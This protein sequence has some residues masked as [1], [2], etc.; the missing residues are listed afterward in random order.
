[1]D[2]AARDGHDVLVSPISL[3][4]LVYLV[5]KNRRPAAAYDD[6]RDAL[7]DPDYAIEE[8][9]FHSEIVTAMRSVPR[10]SVPDLPDRIIA[11][12]ALFFGVP[13]LSRDGDTDG[14]YRP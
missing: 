11:A 8:A 7:A 1:M 5:E 10:A 14:G 4:E 9:P 12:T 13:L 2:A 3:A 6:L